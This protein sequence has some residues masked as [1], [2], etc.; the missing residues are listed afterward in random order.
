MKKRIFALLTALVCI[1]AI[2]SCGKET[3]YSLYNES[4][5]KL[6]AA[7]GYEVN[8]KTD[9]KVEV[10]GQ[11]QD[12]TIEMKLK[13]NGNNLAM[14]TNVDVMGESVEVSVVYVDGTAYT[15]MGDVKYKASVSLEELKND[16]GMA[17]FELPGM[18]EEDLKEIELKEDGDNRSFTVTLKGD[19]VKNF[20]ENMGDLTDGIFDEGVEFSFGDMTLEYTF[21]KDSVMTN[22]TADLSASAE[23]GGQS[24]SMTLKMVYDIVNIGT[25]PTITAPADADSYI[26]ADE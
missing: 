2:A 9:I 1:F 13:A 12:N 5:E 17:S 21:N 8:V 26:S 7:N 24:I 22:M 19:D 14:D 25:A 6:N 15:T 18:T 3:A 20:M 16:S 23:V 4:V 10:A 11:T